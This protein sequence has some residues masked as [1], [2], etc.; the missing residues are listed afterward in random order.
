M[1]LLCCLTLPSGGIGVTKNAT[2][3]RLAIYTSNPKAAIHCVNNE[4]SFYNNLHYPLVLRG[5]HGRSFPTKNGTASETGEALLH[6]IRPGGPSNCEGL[7]LKEVWSR[8]Y[9]VQPFTTDQVIISEINV[10]FR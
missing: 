5:L 3:G 2:C 9:L 10:Q 4:K 1:Y 7:E 8:K 6:A